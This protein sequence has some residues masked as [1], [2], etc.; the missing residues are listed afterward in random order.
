MLR[1]FIFLFLI[2]LVTSNLDN[3]YKYLQVIDNTSSSS[4]ALYDVVEELFIRRG[5]YFDIYICGKA[6]GFFN[7]QIDNFLKMFG[8][9]RAIKHEWLTY[10]KESAVIFVNTE[11][12]GFELN[13]VA[14]FN[15][16][17][18]DFVFVIISDCLN[19]LKI[20]KNPSSHHGH[21]SHFAYLFEDN[22][23]EI[24][25]KTFE[26][27]TEKACNVQQL[28]NLNTFDKHSLSWRREL[29]IPQKFSNFH[30]CS[31]KYTT[32]IFTMN[33]LEILSD[34]ELLAFDKDFQF[35]SELRNKHEKKLQEIFAS[36][37]N[38]TIDPESNDVEGYVLHGRSHNQ[39]LYEFMMYQRSLD[40]FTAGDSNVGYCTTPFFEQSIYA[41]YSPPEPYTNYEKMTMPFDYDTWIYLI[42]VFFVAFIAINVVNYFTEFREILYGKGIKMPSFNVVRTFFGIGQ[43]KLPE[44]NFA[45]II[46]VTFI[47]FCLIFR[48]AYQGEMKF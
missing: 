28:I 25:L 26:W 10:F 17:P 19:C 29:K 39:T 46:L 37:A 15:E 38:F 9:K 4:H 12:Y 18:K 35:L 21:I 42:I 41:M 43:T 6:T 16:F 27:W 3:K 24:E 22:G 7:D 23:K 2:T 47:I 14:I 45:R 32:S 31:I 36:Y 44:N 1:K 11:T 5:I 48:T 13:N 8:Q 30:N 34:F 33:L 20:V 40:M